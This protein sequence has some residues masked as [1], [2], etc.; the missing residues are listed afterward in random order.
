MH[1]NKL[2]ILLAAAASPTASSAIRK[3]TNSQASSCYASTSLEQHSSL[4][5]NPNLRRGNMRELGKAEAIVI[6]YEAGSGELARDEV[7][8]AVKEV[9]AGNKT[10]FQLNMMIKDTLQVLLLQQD[11]MTVSTENLDSEF[12]LVKLLSRIALMSS[13]KSSVPQ[14]TVVTFALSRK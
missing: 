11:G 10:T 4:A 1:I 9:I 14:V 3:Q 2:A 7:V 8:K 12:T 6:D 5:A 13:T